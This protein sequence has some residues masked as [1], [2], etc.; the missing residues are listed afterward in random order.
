[1]TV[2]NGI[3]IDRIEYNTNPTKTAILN[4]Q[5]IDDILHVIAVVSNPALFGRRYVLAKQFIHRMEEESNVVVYT[6]E[7]AYGSQ[8]YY[9]TDPKNPRHLQLHAETPLWHK[10]NMV[11]LGVQKLLPSN[12]KAMAWIDADVEFENTGWAL[13]TLKILNGYKDIVQVFSH[14]VDMDSD[15]STMRIFSSFGFQYDKQQPYSKNTL[16]F[17]HP[18]YAW[19][20]TKNA[21]LRIGG[22]YEH[23]I[24]GSADNIMSLSAIK[25]GL[26]G[27]NQEST[28]GYKSS[29]LSFETKMKS[30]RLGYVPGVIRHHYHG[31]KKNRKYDER[32]RI[33]LDNEYDPAEHITTNEN[34][35]V[36]PTAKCPEKII[37][38][39]QEYFFAR[40]EDE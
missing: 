28:Q 32:W 5:P 20:I 39:I 40:N 35:I 4:N 23:A 10:E 36:I 6:V 38:G 8:K 19:A 34:G 25:N 2:I 26:K 12:W 31:K 14:C 7:L 15:E 11:N 29:I 16:N 37:T 13:D 17:W 1:M 9:L 24:L 3:E 27:I 33:L 30:L 18:G 22:L 21:Y